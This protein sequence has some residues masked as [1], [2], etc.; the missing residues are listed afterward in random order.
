MTRNIIKTQEHYKTNFLMKG[1]YNGLTQRK[2]IVVA[3][4][5]RIYYHNN[6]YLQT[7]TSSNYNKYFRFRN[8]LFLG[9]RLL[10]VLYCICLP[11][12]VLSR[13]DISRALETSSRYRAC[14]A[15]RSQ[16]PTIYVRVAEFKL[17]QDSRPDVYE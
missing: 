12:S 9:N 15:L 17:S 8:I 5:Q 7:S 6:W 14:F 16:D 2:A 4:F 10:T 11:L 3:E 13:S 1:G